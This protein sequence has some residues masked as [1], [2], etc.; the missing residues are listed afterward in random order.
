MLAFVDER[1]N[2]KQRRLLI[3]R[4]W[5]D[6]GL[7]QA[8]P[9]LLH[10][11]PMAI[12]LLGQQPTQVLPSAQAKGQGPVLIAQLRAGQAQARTQGEE[13]AGGGGQQRSPNAAKAVRG[14]AL[15]SFQAAGSAHAS[16]VRP[17][18]ATGGTRLQMGSRGPLGG[19]VG[20]P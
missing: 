4:G 17:L 2:R 8:G 15:S 20:L 5:L 6:G 3:A 19:L 11:A 1:K 18:V 7:D 9:E 16:E 13:Q 14:A 10:L 12:L